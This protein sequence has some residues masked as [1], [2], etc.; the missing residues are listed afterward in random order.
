MIGRRTTRLHHTALV[1]A[2]GLLAAAHKGLAE[3]KESAVPAWMQRGCVRTYNGYVVKVRQPETN[4]AEFDD[5][6]P[7]TEVPSGEEHEVNGGLDLREEAGGLQRLSEEL[8]PA[9]PVPLP[10]LTVRD[11]A[12]DGKD[13]KR[14]KNWILPPPGKD[15]GDPEVD[16]DSDDS[17]D[18]GDE[19][20]MRRDRNGDE[21]GEDRSGSGWGWL[22]DARRKVQR[23]EE[24]VKQRETEKEENEKQRLSVLGGSGQ[25]DEGV[26]ADKP[27]AS[28]SPVVSDRTVEGKSWEQGYVI[29]NQPGGASPSQSRLMPGSGVEPNRT[30]F[31]RVG[32]MRD[33]LSPG[34]SSSKSFSV[35]G[36]GDEGAGSLL[37][38]NPSSSRSGSLLNSQGSGPFQGFSPTSAGRSSSFQPVTVAPAQPAGGASAGDL[39]GNPF[40]SDR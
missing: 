5:A 3:D 29:G 15:D 4:R 39:F 11:R 23:R 26:A 9:V 17:D 27:L 34:A 14:K 7:S 2:V 20:L 16:E 36:P 40:S 31:P 25:N 8:N 33:S 1:A 28:Y 38:P 6:A 35:L 10:I 32:L 12:A 30:G 21:D 18:S 24:R 37:R 22:E 19:G 13:K